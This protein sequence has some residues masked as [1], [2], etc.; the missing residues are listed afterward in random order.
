[1]DSGESMVVRCGRCGRPVLIAIARLLRL[2][3]FDCPLCSSKKPRR[4]AA[5]R[6]SE[7]GEDG[8]EAGNILADVAKHLT[9]KE[10]SILLRKTL[11]FSNEAVMRAYGVGKA[12]LEDLERRAVGLIRGR[13]SS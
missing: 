13:P 10:R 2:R 7:S 12:E 4:P 5:G 6:S 1:M 11:G 9:R 3:T 8:A